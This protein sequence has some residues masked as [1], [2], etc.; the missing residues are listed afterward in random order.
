MGIGVRTIKSG[1][2]KGKFVLHNSVDDSRS[3]PL[4]R[5]QAILSIHERRLFDVKLKFIE[6]AMSFPNG[7][8]DGDCH[9]IRDPEGDQAWREFMDQALSHQDDDGFSKAV[10]A[11]YDELMAAT[12]K[13]QKGQGK[14]AVEVKPKTVAEKELLMGFTSEELYILAEVAMANLKGKASYEWT[15]DQLDM[16]DDVLK[17]LRAKLAEFMG[18]EVEED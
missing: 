10:D 1:P 8:S 4:T 6:D 17:P 14:K 16:S 13:G 15:A 3:D 9:V 11:K 5:E 2:N 7:W 18:D 12:T